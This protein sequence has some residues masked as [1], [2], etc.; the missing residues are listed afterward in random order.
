MAE[1]ECYDVDDSGRHQ[2]LTIKPSIARLMPYKDP[3]PGLPAESSKNERDSLWR[4]IDWIG[5]ILDFTVDD[6]AFRTMTDRRNGRT[7]SLARRRLPQVQAGCRNAYPKILQGRCEQRD[8]L[9]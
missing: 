7:T 8:D 4:R 2:R 9:A 5:Q 1:G 3:D 6:P